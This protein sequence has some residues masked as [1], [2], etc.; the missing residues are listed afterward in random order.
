M[1][2]TSLVLSLS[3]SLLLL[4]TGVTTAQQATPSPTPTPLKENFGKKEE[5]GHHHD[6]VIRYFACNQD[7]AQPINIDKIDTL[8]W[9]ATWDGNNFMHTP[10]PKATGN[11]HPESFMRYLTWDGSCWEASWDAKKEQFN[12]KRVTTGATHPDKILNYLTWDRTK[13]TATLDGDEFYHI[14]VAPAENE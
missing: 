4:A 3:V 13:W 7:Y 14:Y 6:K 5:Y 1:K 11:S 10:G 9:E 8:R 2:R 12:H